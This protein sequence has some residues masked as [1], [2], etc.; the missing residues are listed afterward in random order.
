MPHSTY[1]QLAENDFSMGGT[2]SQKGKGVTPNHLQLRHQVSN[3]TN[4]IVWFLTGCLEAP[5]VA[6]PSGKYPG[7]KEV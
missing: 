1:K 3:I 7:V 5:H 4:L 2:F 6:S